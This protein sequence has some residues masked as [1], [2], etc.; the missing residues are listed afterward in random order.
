MK[1]TL[2]RTEK[3]KSAAMQIQYQRSSVKKPLDFS[4]AFPTVVTLIRGS[5]LGCIT[6]K[7]FRWA[8]NTSTNM[9]MRQTNE[10]I[11]TMLHLSSRNSFTTIAF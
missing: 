5:R 8:S 11:L 3:P 4:T 2:N 6:Q 7:M 10:E 1:Q 9:M